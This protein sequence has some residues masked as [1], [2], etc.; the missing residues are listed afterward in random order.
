M[1]PER[2]TKTF[3][4]CRT[5]IITNI[6]TNIIMSINM[7]IIMTTNMNIIMTTIT[8]QLLSVS[9]GVETTVCGLS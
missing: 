4:S 7:N 8:M 1:H 2:I 3:E 6:N 9:V 5:N